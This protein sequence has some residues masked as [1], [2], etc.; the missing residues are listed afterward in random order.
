MLRR[1]REQGG[2]GPFGLRRE[3][4]MEK[5]GE[6]GG[7]CSGAEYHGGPGSICDCEGTLD[8][9]AKVGG[10][11]PKVLDPGYRRAC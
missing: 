9:P 3:G 11:H 1:A 5:P 7:H 4:T 6:D 8:N 2:S 10:G